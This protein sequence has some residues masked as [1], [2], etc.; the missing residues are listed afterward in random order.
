LRLS[1]HAVDLR[2]PGLGL[3]GP[4]LEEEDEGKA[5]ELGLQKPARKS[6]TTF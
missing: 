4:G 2:H 3:R 5:T 1:R 6:G